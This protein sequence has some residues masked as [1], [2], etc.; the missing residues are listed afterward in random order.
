[1]DQWLELMLHGRANLLLHRQEP[2]L[3]MAALSTARPVVEAAGGT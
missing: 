1:M 2:E 3:A